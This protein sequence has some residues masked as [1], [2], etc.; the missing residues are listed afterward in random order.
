MICRATWSPRP[1]RELEAKPALND[2]LEGE[3]LMRNSTKITAALGGVALS[4]ATAG[5]AYAYWTTTGSGSGTGATT[6]GVTDTLSFTQTA[7]NAMYP[8][9]SSQTLT[10]AVKNT[11]ANQKVYVSGVKAYITTDKEGCTGA[12]FLLGG[13][14]TAVDATN[15][16]ALAWT[17]QELAPTVSANATSTIQFNN[18]GSPQ[19]ACK[20]AIVTV[21]YLAS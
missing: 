17:A 7:L 12:D 11:D 6:A 1:G 9:D 8:G 4:V 20:S 13:A 16:K 15:A 2:L 18:T 14:A 3:N 10:V 5:A 21:H 19:D